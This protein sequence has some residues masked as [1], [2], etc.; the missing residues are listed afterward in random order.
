MQQGLRLTTGVELCDQEAAPDHRQISLAEQ[1]ARQAIDLGDAQEENP[2]LG[3]RPTFPDSRPAIG[4]LPG[5]GN[6]WVSFGHQHIGFSTGPGSA[7]ILADLME[8]RAPP[9][10]AGPFRPG[11]YIHRA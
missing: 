1:A 11:R 7:R 2:W 10:P 9:I 3:A 8:G 4:A 5:A 6:L